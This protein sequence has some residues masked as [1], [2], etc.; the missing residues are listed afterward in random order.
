VD[1]KDVGLF[2]ITLREDADGDV[3]IVTDDGF[4]YYASFY[5]T[6]EHQSAFIEPPFTVRDIDRSNGSMT[7]LTASTEDTDRKDEYV[8]L[9]VVTMLVGVSVG[10]LVAGL[11]AAWVR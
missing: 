3:A 6:P 11:L 10:L 5:V 4:T 9:H 2:E 1:G 7:D 8:G